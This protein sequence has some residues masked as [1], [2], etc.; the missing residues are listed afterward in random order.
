MTTGPC[1]LERR[2]ELLWL[3]AESTYALYTGLA[4]WQRE[5][6]LRIRQIEIVHEPAGVSAIVLIG[7]MPATLTGRDGMDTVVVHEGR[8]LTG[9]G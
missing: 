7:P 6:G 3:Q 9:S 4:D 8:L 2:G 1:R 5:Q